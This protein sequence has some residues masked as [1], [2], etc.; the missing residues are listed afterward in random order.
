MS[1]T[2]L[3]SIRKAASR[4]EAISCFV[5]LLTEHREHI[6]DVK[7]RV[8]QVYQ[9]ETPDCPVFQFDVIGFEYREG[10]WVD[11]GLD[12]MLDSSLQGLAFKLE[13][14]PESD[15]VPL[16]HPGIGKSDLIPRMF[17][18][19][20]D[21][22]PDGSVIQQFN[23]IEKLPR[24][25]AKLE[26]VDVVQ[27][28]AWRDVVERIR[29][30]VETTDGQVEIAYPQMQ[31]PLTNVPR[32]MDHTEMLMACHTDPQSMCVLANTWADVATHLILTLQQVVGDPVLLRPRARFYQP[33]WIRGLIVG[34]YLAVM[35]PEQYYDICVDAW[36]TVYRRLGPIFYH[37]CGPVW[38][39][40]EVLKKLPGLVGFECTYVKGQTGTTTDLMEVKRQLDGKI[41][42]H[43]FEWPLR[44]AVE[45]VENLTPE[46]LRQMSKGG[47]FMMQ[48]SG[49]VEE[50]QALFEK[51]ELI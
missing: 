29:F 49:T 5:R 33:G 13:S 45:D 1:Y 12:R 31:G 6:A 38:R 24:D 32:L 4:D 2:A 10:R 41:V 27:T 16:L 42:L 11:S 43:H 51:L 22:P 28:E 25:L 46:W 15:F 37:T 14:M 23:L 3:E 26:G 39:S 36:D 44:G 34:D 50:G 7:E 30:L 9:F 48:A 35:R 17:G 19:T 40:L 18:V 8:K 21:Y 20:F 47:G